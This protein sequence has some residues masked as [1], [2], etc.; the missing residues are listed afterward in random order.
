MGLPPLPLEDH[1]PQQN[2]IINICL[3]K[4][5]S[6]PKL[7]MLENEML[8]AQPIL[9]FLWQCCLKL[10]LPQNHRHATHPSNK[11]LSGFKPLKANCFQ[12]SL[13]PSNMKGGFT[14]RHHVSPPR[15]PTSNQPIV[16]KRKSKTGNP[17]HIQVH[18]GTCEASKLRNYNKTKAESVGIDKDPWGAANHFLMWSI[19]Y[20]LLLDNISLNNG[21]NL[22]K[23][24]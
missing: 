16:T 7:P 19:Y 9:S 11:Q 12:K 13:Q 15:K 20:S 3:K 14:V 24:N 2:M 10:C 23:L 18:L 4:N 21:A 5:M 22:G 1:Q 8:R 6:L 17:H